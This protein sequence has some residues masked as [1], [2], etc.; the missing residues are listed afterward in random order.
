MKI[1]EILRLFAFDDGVDACFHAPD[2]RTEDCRI[3][4]SERALV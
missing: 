1:F 3:A 2:Y 4:S